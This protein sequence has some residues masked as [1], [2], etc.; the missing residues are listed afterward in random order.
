V[1][2]ILV[3]ESHS[4]QWSFYSNSRF[5]EARALLL[6]QGH[7]LTNLAGDPGAIT[8]SA[9]E[10][11]DVFYSGTL[12]EPM[13][14]SEVTALQDFVAAGGGVI[15]CHD[16]GWSSDTA[17]GSVNSFLSLYGM[18]LSGSADYASGIT[19]SD[20]AVHS[21]TEGVTSAVFDYLR[22]LSQIESPAL[23]LTNSGV[24][25]LGVYDDSS[26]G[27][28]IVIGDDSQWTNVGEGDDADIGDA[29]NEQLT[30][31]VFNYAGSE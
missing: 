27:W 11:S 19:A 2:S 18:Q 21:L 14:D 9:L 1:L 31:N 8:E 28:V 15:C 10:G 13:L 4:Q 12:D 7:T 17:V 3:D 22:E 24:E 25:I 5:S 30:L 16:G 23:D 26:G 6:G 29:D 20:F